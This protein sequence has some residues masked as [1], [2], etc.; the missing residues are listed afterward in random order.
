MPPDQLYF[1]MQG[2]IELYTNGKAKIDVGEVQTWLDYSE[3]VPRLGMRLG[4]LAWVV[5]SWPGLGG[6]QLLWHAL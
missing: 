5:H 1:D 2:C 4:V 6:A 3:A